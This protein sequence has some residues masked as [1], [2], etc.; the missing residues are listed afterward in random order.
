VFFRQNQT[1][2]LT[3]T[4]FYPKEYELSVNKKVILDL[5]MLPRFTMAV[6]PIER[7]G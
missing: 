2:P 5:G 7:S 3:N 6:Y 4:S 1:F